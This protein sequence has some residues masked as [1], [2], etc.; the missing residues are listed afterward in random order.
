MIVRSLMSMFSRLPFLIMDWYSQPFH[1]YTSL[2]STSPGRS[3]AGRAWTE[4]LSLLLSETNLYSRTWRITMREPAPSSSS[5]MKPRWLS[6]WRI[7][8]QS[9]RSGHAIVLYHRGLT[10]NAE[11]L[12]GGLGVWRGCTGEHSPRVTGPTGYASSAICIRSIGLENIHSFIHSGYLYSAP[13]RN[14]L[15]GALSPATVKEKCLKKL[16]ERRDV[17]LR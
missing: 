3:A 5:Y 14:L 2:S 1:L 10:L 4:R 16:A 7:S 9:I 17:V 8:L 11:L 6:S 13:S 12:D 15:R